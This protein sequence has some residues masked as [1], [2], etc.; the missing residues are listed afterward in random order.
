VCVYALP[1]LLCSRISNPSSLPPRLF[2]TGRPTQLIYQGP[3]SYLL[4]TYYSLRTRF[5]GPTAMQPIAKRPATAHSTAS[6]LPGG[7]YIPTGAA[8]WVRCHY[9]KHVLNTH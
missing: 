8:E 6:T 2:F 5:K 4:R 9:F 1:P 7:G 3:T